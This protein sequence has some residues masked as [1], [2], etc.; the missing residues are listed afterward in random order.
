MILDHRGLPIDVKVL[1]QPVI[2]IDS[3][4]RRWQYSPLGQLT[5]HRVAYILNNSINGDLNEFVLW[6]SEIEQRD[7]H[8]GSVLGIRKRAVSGL[9]VNIEAAS[10]S[11]EDIANADLARTL[12]A[13]SEFRRMLSATLD[14]LSKGFACIELVW[15][16]GK[17]WYPSYVWRDPRYF[18]ID[19][20]AGQ[21]IRL[22]TTTSI[23]G[24]LLPPFKF[25]VHIPNIDPGHIL[26]NSL[27]RRA[28]FWNMCKTFNIGQWMSFIE[29]FGMPLRIGKYEAHATEEERA[30]LQMAVENLGIDAAATIPNSMEIDFKETTSDRANELFSSF[31]T[32]VDNQISKM[33]LGQIRTTD[34]SAVGLARASEAGGKDEVRQD[35]QIADAADLEDTLNRDL[36][37]PFIKLNRGEFEQY[38]RLSLFI[39]KREDLGLLNQMLKDQ[40]PNG[41]RVEQSVIRDKFGLPD[42]ADDSEL[43][44]SAGKTTSSL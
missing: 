3:W 33:V 28:L 21:E 31:A 18:L 7:L 19:K 32:Y 37:E 44:S 1:N 40:I 17:V 39:P 8:Y 35:I 26:F 22:N 5:P 12:V 20:N 42:P 6:A 2:K 16:F 43:L 15:N 9:K 14:A 4:R 30:V 27:S 13:R 29:I 34:E 24:E 10:D 41:L 11:A 25:I 23:D 36:I 38:P